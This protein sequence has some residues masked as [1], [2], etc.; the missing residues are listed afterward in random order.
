MGLLEKASNIEAEAEP[1]ETKGVKP[2]KEAVKEP[3]AK[4]PKKAAKK[5]KKVKPPKEKKPRA[6]RVKKELPEGFELA[7]KSQKFIRRLLDFAVNYGWSVPLIALS[8][9]GA[10]FNPCLLY[11]SPSPRDS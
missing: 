11:T 5:P 10:F 9:W 1:P 7:T 3:P 4:K 6:P 2:K 8:A